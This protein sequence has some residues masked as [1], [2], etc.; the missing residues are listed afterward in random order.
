MNNSFKIFKKNGF[1]TNNLMPDEKLNPD[2]TD[3]EDA[4]SGDN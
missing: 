2:A 1:Y 3:D 4:N